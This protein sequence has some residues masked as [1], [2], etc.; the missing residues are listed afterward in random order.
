MRWANDLADFQFSIK[1]RPGRENFDADYLSRRPLS[2][3]EYKAECT[4]QYGPQEI[5]AV[6]SNALTVKPVVVNHVLAKQ[7]VIE[8]VSR[9]K[10]VVSLRELVEKQQVDKVV[11]L[12]YQCVK[13]GSRPTRKEWGQLL[14][15]SK[16]LL[17]G[18]GKLWISEKGVLLRKTVRYRQIVL[19]EH[20]HQLVQRTS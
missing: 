10:L 2:I 16:S 19:P 11:G 17:K 1:Y 13:L 7:A 20:Y 18:F 12:V 14:P 4:E 5:Q 3:E 8:P 9:G 15:G 6:I